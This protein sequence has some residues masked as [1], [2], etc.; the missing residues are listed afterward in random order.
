MLTWDP[1]GEAN[2][3]GPICQPLSGQGTCGRW[4]CLG[5]L[6]GHVFA[7]TIR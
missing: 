2:R 4:D 7:N 5:A 3:D 1:A 6:C